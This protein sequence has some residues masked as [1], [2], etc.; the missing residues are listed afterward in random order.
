MEMN[1]E[2][3]SIVVPVYNV[4]DYLKRCVES[5]MQQTY[6]NIEIILVNDGST[7]ASGEMCD[8]LAASDSRITV[9]HQEN[10]GLSAARNSGLR[11]AQGDYLM[12]VDSDDYIALDSCESFL[13]YCDGQNDI[14]LADC[15]KIDGDAVSY[16][17][18]THATPG[19]V[20]HSRDF[21]IEA[22]KSNEWYAPACFNLY[23][24]QFLIDNHLFFK[25]GIL[26]EDVQMLPRLYL[27]ANKVV[28]LKKVFYHYIIRENSIMTSVQ[29]DRNQKHSLQVYKDWFDILETVDDKDY[30]RYLDGVWVKYYLSNCRSWKIK[31]WQIE[32]MPFTFAL[33]RAL[34]V[35]ERTKV[36]LFQ[37]FPSWYIR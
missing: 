36:L 19:K 24:R 8:E 28:Y 30:R 7:D 25:Q 9:V 12:Y 13:P 10:G 1:E 16:I 2:L 22:I 33:K 26:F 6:T 23:R 27:A 21:V 5:L 11:V 15:Q 37:F 34:N 4:S 32:S 35:K 18:H 17:E 14:I 31:G 20:Y 3:I 29:L